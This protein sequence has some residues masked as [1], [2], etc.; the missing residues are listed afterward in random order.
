MIMFPTQNPQQQQQQQQGYDGYGYGG[1]REYS[2]FPRYGGGSFV[3]HM[4]Y[5]QY[6]YDEP[7]YLESD[8]IGLVGN[9]YHR[10]QQ[11][12]HMAE[13]ESRTSSVNEA[14]S[15]SRD[16]D[17]KQGDDKWLQL[18][19]GNSVAED[20]E[21]NKLTSKTVLDEE[22]PTPRRDDKLVE[23][24]L[25]SGNST[26]GT[27]DVKLSTPIFHMTSNEFRPNIPPPFR[28]GG[29]HINNNSTTGTRISM[30]YF[31]HH[32]QSRTT[33]LNLSTHSHH[34]LQPEHHLAW[35]A[36]GNNSYNRSNVWNPT[37]GASASPLPLMSN[38]YNYLRSPSSFQPHI[39]VDIAGPSSSSTTS[40]NM[41]M[42]VIDTPPRPHSGI[43]FVL[44]ASPNQ[45]KEPFLPQIPKS[46]LRIKDGRMPVRLLMKYLANKLRLNSE[47]EI[48][49]RCRGQ[50][51]DPF[52][53]LQHVRDHIWNPK[54]DRDQLLMMSLLQ[55]SSTT[56]S[57]DNHVMIL[58]YGTNPNT[59]S[60][61][62]RTT[63]P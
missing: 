57:T 25:L 24:D 27:Q 63:T 6:S 45:S 37:V 15:S 12:H 31:I 39:N 35:A 29:I 22:Q 61:V 14:G 40:D 5:D 2:Y 38:S 20:S 17:Q 10:Q 55:D 30:P 1:C 44:Q 60:T 62:N 33:S 4:R 54:D 18:G 3:D 53:T 8:I 52:L 48:E 32:Q 46:Y 50:Q 41:V 47:S 43:W 42:K 21:L 59:S 58:H 16:L 34:H 51:L 49:I 56:T 19:I 11:Q 26:S 28:S 23:L 9:R 13:D 7:I 36:A